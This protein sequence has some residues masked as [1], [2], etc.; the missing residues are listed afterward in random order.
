[1]NYTIHGILQARIL[2]WVAFHGVAEGRTRLSEFT[3]TFH[4]HA[5]EK[6]MATHSSV[7]AWRIPG[8]GEPGGLPSLGSHRVGH[9]WSDLA[10][11]AAA[12]FPFSRGSSQPRDWT[13][14]SCIAGG[15]FTSWATREAQVFK[16]VHIFKSRRNWVKLRELE[17]RL[18]VESWVSEPANF[19]TDFKL[20]MRTE[21]AGL[22][23]SWGKQLSNLDNCH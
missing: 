15:F 8:T 6:E 9:D 4:F 10:A 16:D 3:F 11:A 5:L 23:R 14:V 7:L 13:Q 21:L 22:V 18:C 20:S 17:K 12:A 19:W 1:M 2:E